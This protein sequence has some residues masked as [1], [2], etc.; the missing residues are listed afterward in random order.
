MTKF[1]CFP[2]YAPSE[3]CTLHVIGENSGP[4][5]KGQTSHNLLAIP[6]RDAHPKFCGCYDVIE[7][8]T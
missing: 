4:K 8:T 1:T 2:L 7:A 5:R 6:G 3:A